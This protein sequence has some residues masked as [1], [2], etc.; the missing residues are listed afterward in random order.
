MQHFFHFQQ[1]IALAFHHFGDRNTGHA[2]N[3]FGYFVGAHFGA[4]QFIGLRRF[5]VAFNRVQLFGELRQFA[6]FQFGCAG[7]ITLALGLLDFHLDI[8]DLFFDV[9]GTGRRSF[10]RFPD[11]VQIGVFF[12]QTGDFFVDQF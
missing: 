6:V 5:G 7:K 8:V 10:F 2:R 3:D 4:E 12:L 11:F 9:G 1:L